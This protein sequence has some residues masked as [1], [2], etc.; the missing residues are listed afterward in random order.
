MEN[1]GN[2]YTT[3]FGLA[4]ANNFFASCE[5]VFRPDLRN[6]PI[7]ILSN[8][9]GCIIARSNEAKALGIGMAVPYYQAKEIIDKHNVKVFS[10]NYV[11]YGDMSN[12]VMSMLS[13]YS[14]EVE[15]YSIDE[16][17]LNFTGFDHYNLQ[18]YGED[19]VQKITRGTG[20]PISLGIAPTK[21]LAKMANKFAKSYKGYK[22]VCLIDS[23]EKRI[24]ALQ[25]TPVEDVW[26]IGRRL[27]KFLAKYDIRTAYDF[28][29]KS[30]AWV[31][32]QMTV[33]GERTWKELN[34][35]SC[36][37]V[38]HIP[39][40]KHSICTSRMF[41]VPLTKLDDM[42]EAVSTYAGLC[43]SKLRKQNSCAASLMVFV[44]TSHV[45][46]RAQYFA[47]SVHISFPVP[48]N[49]TT[50]I[51]QYAL[52]ALKKAYKEGYRYKK[53]GVIIT[54]TIPDNA[55]QQNL[56]DQVDRNK[57]SRLMP[58]VDKL[59]AGFDRNLLMLANQ[60]GNQKWKARRDH[61]SPCYSTSLNDLI[62][63]RIH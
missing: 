45:K 62:R 34:G 32:Q 51:V 60:M 50:E 11:L 41:G 63:V 23:E 43:A 36:I 39:P 59:N 44:H 33:T 49:L 22:G 26:G 5:R 13:S 10:S 56:F 15:I 25:L 31:R 35:I 9:D 8:N 47:N 48:T 2:S 17:F 12:R 57:Q 20:I 29:Q 24:K 46:D 18:S 38:D 21:T 1:P 42:T 19:M 16:A 14:P 4:D 55:V 61:L 58:I 6:T 30:C 40:Q 54:E 52:I 27:A 28:T 7:V 53:A 3:M 37:D